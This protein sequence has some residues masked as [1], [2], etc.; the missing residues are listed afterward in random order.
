MGENYYE[1]RAQFVGRFPIRAI[2]FSDHAEKAM[3]DEMIKLVE[4]MLAL[5]K[6]VGQITNLSNNEK[7][8]LERQ[9]KSTDR[10]IDE[11]V[12]RLYGLTPEEIRIVE[13]D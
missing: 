9:I 8:L 13:G 2:N 4:Q 10:Q 11:L 3:H 1:F 5:H 7:E 12:Y 6:Q